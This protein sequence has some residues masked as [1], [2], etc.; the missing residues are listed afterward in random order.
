MEMGIRA[1]KL[2]VLRNLLEERSE[3]CALSIGWVCTSCSLCHFLFIKSL[4][5]L[6]YP[7]GVLSSWMTWELRRKDSVLGARGWW[8]LEG[9]LVLEPPPH[10]VLIHGHFKPQFCSPGSQPSCPPKLSLGYKHWTSPLNLR[11]LKHT[12][13]TL[14]FISPFMISFLP[15]SQ[16]TIL[17]V[18]L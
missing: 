13:A 1:W 11:S 2:E 16:Q 3:L 18:S 14:S 7:Q 9:I 10:L 4:A 15:T 6:V 5:T 12:F 8:D 17:E